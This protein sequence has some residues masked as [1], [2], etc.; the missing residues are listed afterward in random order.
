MVP[1]EHIRGGFSPSGRGEEGRMFPK[2]GNHM[3]KGSVMWGARYVQD[4][5]RRLGSLSPENVHKVKW[6]GPTWARPYRI[7][8]GF[9]FL[10]LKMGSY[11]RDLRIGGDGMVI[12]KDYSDPCVEVV[13]GGKGCRAQFL[14]VPCSNSVNV[15][16]WLTSLW[17]LWGFF[18]TR[19]FSFRLQN[20]ELLNL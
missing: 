7:W 1:W 19:S 2:R 6:K 11:W 13:W 8:K 10:S 12:G 4:I 15:A 9:R 17:G 3:S 5:E 16:H 14:P 18:V 20:L